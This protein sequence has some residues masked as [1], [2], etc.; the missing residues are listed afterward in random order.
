M[1]SGA[2]GVVP[3]P[4]AE[5]V[6]VAVPQPGAGN[7]GFGLARGSV[8]DA[9]PCRCFRIGTRNTGTHPSTLGLR[10]VGN[11]GNRNEGGE[12]G[13]KCDDS[14]GEGGNGA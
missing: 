5:R 13:R 3:F 4:R 2:T 8:G 1:A 7:V 14:E 11:E 10:S 12:Q 6:P 9:D